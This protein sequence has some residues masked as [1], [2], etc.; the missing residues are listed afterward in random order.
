MA[1]W[2]WHADEE[3]RSLSKG[4]LYSRFVDRTS[5]GKW[6]EVQEFHPVV[7]EGAHIIDKFRGEG[8]FQKALARLAWEHLITDSNRDPGSAHV[9][10]LRD[11]EAILRKEF[12]TAEGGTLPNRQILAVQK[13]IVL[14]VFVRRAEGDDGLRFAHK[15]FREFLCA[16][17][18]VSALQEI[19]RDGQVHPGKVVLSQAALGQEELLFAADLVRSLPPEGQ[20]RILFTLDV[21]LKEGK[22][23]FLADSEIEIAF[24]QNFGNI[25][26]IRQT[27]FSRGQRA[28]VNAEKLALS[29]RNRYQVLKAL[30][31]MSGG[32]ITIRNDY[33]IF[34]NLPVDIAYRI[35]SEEDALVGLLP[36]EIIGA[37]DLEISIPTYIT[38][39]GMRAFNVSPSFYILGATRVTPEH[40]ESI[41]NL[42]LDN[43]CALGREIVTLNMEGW[44]FLG[45]GRMIHAHAWH[46][47]SQWTIGPLIRRSNR[48]PTDDDVLH[49]NLAFNTWF[50]FAKSWLIFNHLHFVDTELAAEAFDDVL[51]RPV[52]AKWLGFN[53]GLNRTDLISVAKYDAF[54]EGLVRLVD[55]Y[56]VKDTAQ[57]L[58]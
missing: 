37:S 29:I 43:L 13:S 2:D 54:C 38:E 25:I 55:H 14:S 12:C 19:S 20:K 41:I 28:R 6:K 34:D 51:I 23:I 32:P 1:A 40:I 48:V 27:R 35:D 11:V 10:P 36:D 22:L 9:L 31:P 47:G 45:R 18:V 16:K 15:S 49:C 46:R 5:R 4:D 3:S 52:L 7:D 26:S 33:R 30:W 8:S 56:L 50:D 21:I 57:I 44:R 39:G 53:S 42:K 17:Y 58:E 24:Q